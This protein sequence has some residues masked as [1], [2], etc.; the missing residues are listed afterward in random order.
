MQ[1]ET[2]REAIERLEDEIERLTLK[3]ERCRKLSLAAK[4]A[5]AAGALWLVTTLIGLAPFLPSLFF[6]ALAV[7]IGGIVL[8]GSNATTWD[9][10]EAA[11]G[12]AEAARARLI[13]TIELRVVDEGVRQLH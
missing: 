1:N 7:I 2:A 3:R 12:K 9:Q 11:I 10:T 13:G 5:I 6:G 8:L 4:I